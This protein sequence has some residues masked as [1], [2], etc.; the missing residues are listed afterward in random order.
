DAALRVPL[1]FRWPAHIKP[2]SSDNAHL[3]TNVDIAPTLLEIAGVPIP[4]SM[5]GQSFL[6]VLQGQPQPSRDAFYYEFFEYPDYDHCARK[7]RGLR[8][9]KWKLIEYWEQPIEYE[10][11]DL[12]HDPDETKNLAKTNASMVRELKSRMDQL[13]HDLGEIDAPGPVPAVGPCTPRTL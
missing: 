10:L 13:R 8:T 1:L 2:A 9:A 12:Q 7:H 11:Y 4:S 5:Q 3:L 6:R